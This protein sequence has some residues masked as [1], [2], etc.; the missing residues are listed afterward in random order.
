MVPGTGCSVVGKVLKEQFGGIQLGRKHNDVSELLDKQ[1]LDEVELPNYLIFANIRNPFDRLVTYYQRLKG[2]WTTEYFEWARRDLQRRRENNEFTA[3]ELQKKLAR[4][5]KED[6]RKSRRM[7]I[8]RYVGFNSWLHFTLFRWYFRGKRD[9]QLNPL[10]QFIFPMLGRVQYA[11]KQEQLENGFKEVL[12]RAEIKENITLPRKNITQ[13]KKHYTEYYGV[14]TRY[15]TNILLRS[16]LKKFGYT[17]DGITSEK[18]FIY[19][20]S[21]NENQGI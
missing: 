4:L 7:H 3:E 6:A 1:L 9:G 11:I 21:T 13:G 5:S 17:F 16:D 12:K 19:L 10:S 15:I 2:N 18:P 8:I 14:V 20:N